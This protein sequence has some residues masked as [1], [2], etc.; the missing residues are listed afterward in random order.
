MEDQKLITTTNRKSTLVYLGIVTLVEIFIFVVVLLLLPQFRTYLSL[1]CALV[2]VTTFG[3]GVML[4]FAP[5]ATL[6]F[7]NDELFINDI[8]TKEYHVYAVT[9]S[10]FVFMQTPLEKKIN[11]GCLWIKG[12]IFWMCGVKNFAETKAYVADHFPNY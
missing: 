5:P 7:V 9:A 11:L 12:T 3:T 4:A 8:G 2:C 6:R 10:D 1:A